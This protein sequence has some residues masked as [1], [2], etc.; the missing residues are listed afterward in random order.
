[1]LA[2]KKDILPSF[3]QRRDLDRHYIQTVI[4]ILPEL[5]PIDQGVQVLIRGGDHADIHFAGFRCADRCKLLI[6]QHP[7]DLCLQCQRHIADLIQEDR[8]PVRQF[9]FSLAICICTG[10][11]TFAV[12][13]EFGFQKI[14]GDRSAVDHD[15]AFIPALSSLVDRLCH[16][17]LSR[18]ALSGD[19]DVGI[20]VLQGI[21]QFIDPLHTG[22]F[23]DDTVVMPAALQLVRKIGDPLRELSEFQGLFD[24]DLQLFQIQRLRQIGKSTGLHSF[25]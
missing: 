4:Q 2:E 24:N 15:K 13:E 17:F 9:E 11:R 23:S 18:S 21:D 5:F 12:A 1:M 7:Q 6:L 20:D 19:Q 22:A 25:H 10:K 3:P 16:Q 14:V 8:S